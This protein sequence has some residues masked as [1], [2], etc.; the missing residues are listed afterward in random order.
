MAKEKFTFKGFL[1]GFIPALAAASFLYGSVAAF[2]GREQEKRERLRQESQK[3]NV[4]YYQKN[5]KTIEQAVQEG[6]TPGD[7]VQ[8]TNP[9]TLEIIAGI[10]SGFNDGRYRIKTLNGEEADSQNLKNQDYLITCILKRKILGSSTQPTIQSASKP[11]TQP[12]TQSESQPASM[13]AQKPTTRQAFSQYDDLIR[14]YAESRGLDEDLIRAQIKQESRFR[15][16]AKSRV[17]A[18]GL[19]QVMPGTAEELGYSPKDML[20][21][22]KSIEAGTRYM[23][24]Q[25]NTH[26]VKQYPKDRVELALASYNAGYG[27]IIHSI[28]IV[29]D[30]NQG[31]QTYTIIKGKKRRTIDISKLKGVSESWIGFSKALP[32]VTGNSNAK[33]TTEYVGNILGFCKEYQ[34]QK[35]PPVFLARNFCNL[36]FVASRAF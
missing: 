34:S 1:K 30:A 26:W 27:N 8:F 22:E 4:A 36:L 19:M 11:A 7:F 31:K 32:L 6:L 3:A 18:L 20:D 33:Q 16:D 13:P 35:H 17:G 15:A 14:K 25:M 21:P 5:S 28:K 2:S 24:K 10:Y 9:S 23:Q 12:T 29:K